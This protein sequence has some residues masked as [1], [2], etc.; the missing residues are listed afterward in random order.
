MSHDRM[1]D[2]SVPFLYV[3]LSHATNRANINRQYLF[4]CFNV[5]RTCAH[6]YFLCSLASQHFAMK[7]L[8][9]LNE[10]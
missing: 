4:S 8:P 6:V 2:I 9:Q 10:T 7:Y 1:F 3:P 5:Y